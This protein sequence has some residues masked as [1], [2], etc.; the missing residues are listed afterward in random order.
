MN[1]TVSWVVPPPSLPT[2]GFYV[3]YKPWDGVGN[4]N[5]IQAAGPLP[6][7]TTSYTITGLNP[8]TVYR[9]LVSHE[10]LGSSGGFTDESTYLNITCPII[11]V[12]QGGTP[13]NRNLATLYY[14]L[15]Y[16]D[17]LHITS[18]KVGIT[19][20]SGFPNG[21]PTPSFAPIG[22]T[23]YVLSGDLCT[24]P[25]Q[26]DCNLQS[27]D[28]LY[29]SGL[30]SA[31]GYFGLDTLNFQ[32]TCNGTANDPILFNESASYKFYVETIIDSNIIGIDIDF[33]T[34]DQGCI[35]FSSA[36]QW[37]SVDPIP[38]YDQVS[39]SICYNNCQVNL[40]LL[41]AT[42]QNWPGAYQYA[43]FTEDAASNQIPL[44]DN[45]GNPITTSDVSYS[46]YCPIEMTPSLTAAQLG[47]GMNVT[48]E[49]FNPA[50]SMPYNGVNL[51]FTGFNWTQVV[52][53][54]VNNINTNTSLTATAV[55]IGGIDFIKLEPCD[56]LQARIR[57]Y[58]PGIFSGN[59]GDIPQVDPPAAAQHGI[60]D[61]FV[62]TVPGV[63]DFVYGSRGLDSNTTDGAIQVTD[64]TN[65]TPTV[66]VNHQIDIPINQM[67]LVEDAPPTTAY[68][69]NHLEPNT[70]TDPYHC[71]TT[72]IVDNSGASWN[73]GF[74]YT[75]DD[76][77]SQQ[78]SV[79][80]QSNV[81]VD[82]VDLNTFVGL[83]T[84]ARIKY[85][86]VCQPTGHL[87]VLVEDFVGKLNVYKVEHLPPLPV[88][89]AS[90]TWSVTPQPLISSATDFVL[91]T[92]TTNAVYNVQSVSVVNN[93][94][95]VA[96]NPWTNNQ[97]NFYR[98]YAPTVTSVSKQAILYN[99]T[100]PSQ[101][102]FANDSNTLY[103]DA[104]ADVT[105][106]VADLSPGDTIY[107]LGQSDLFFTIYDAAGT[108]VND[109]YN[110][111]GFI[112]EP[113]GISPQ[114]DGKRYYIDGTNSNS[115]P[116]GT[117]SLRI[118]ANVTVGG[119]Y[120]TS[121]TN[122]ATVSSLLPGVQYRLF[123]N[124][125]GAL[126][127]NQ[128]RNVFY[129]SK[130]DGEIIELDQD[131]NQ[132]NQFSLL[133][134]AGNP[135]TEG[136]FQFAENPATGLTYAIMRSVNLS[137]S[138][139][140]ASPYYSKDV[141]RINGAGN[142]IAA[143]NGAARWNEN[144]SGALS[145]IANKLYFTSNQTRRIIEYDT[146][147]TTWT[148]KTIPD[149]Y[150]KSQTVE[151]IESAI[152]IPGP[153]NR[154][155]IIN[156][157]PNAVTPTI[158][159]NYL[160]SN[161]FIYDYD[162]NTIET[163]LMG[164]DT[165]PWTAAEANWNAKNLGE[166]FGEFN[167]FKDYCYG[168]MSIKI[169]NDKIYFKQYAE[170]RYYVATPF[171]ETG[172]AQIW[173]I[174]ENPDGTTGTISTYRLIRIYNIQSDG[175]LVPS[176]RTIY[177]YKYSRGLK[178]GPRYIVY[179]ANNSAVLGVTNSTSELILI[180]VND[181]TGY[182]G[183]PPLGGSVLNIPLSSRMVLY[184]DD[185]SL[186]HK[187]EDPATFAYDDNS[188]RIYIF[189]KQAGGQIYNFQVWGIGAVL[190]QSV[191]PV[192][193]LQ[194]NTGTPNNA[195]LYN[196]GGGSNGHNYPTVFNYT[197]NTIWQMGNEF[198]NTTPG[199]AE[200]DR[201]IKIFNATT[202]TLVNTINL[203]Q[204]GAVTNGATVTNGA[205]DLYHNHFYDP[206]FNQMV[207]YGK[208]NDRLLFIN[209]VTQAITYNGSIVSM[210]NLNRSP[211]LGA[212]NIGW[213]VPYNNGYLVDRNNVSTTDEFWTYI[214]P[215]FAE[216]DGVIHDYITIKVNN[217]A[218]VIHDQV[219]NPIQLYGWSFGHYKVQNATPLPG[220]DV[221]YWNSMYGLLDITITFNDV[222]EIAQM[223]PNRQIIKVENLNQG[224]TYDITNPL[225]VNQP[226]LPTFNTLNSID[227]FAIRADNVNLFNGDF[228]QFTFANPTYPNC[229]YIQLMQIL[230]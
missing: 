62:Y 22:R 191:T 175:S 222:L 8:N 187:I 174:G 228:L 99:Y 122:D 211:Q 195:G 181:L 148:V 127:Y 75:C 156:R 45:A 146:I 188:G 177:T 49:I 110:D 107:M 221:A 163:V 226:Q 186:T 168:G 171:A 176:A 87:I 68:Q 73:D 11:S 158:H 185:V 15:Y 128:N 219:S 3:Y 210:I 112:F 132:T 113:S 133:D 215:S 97:W 166:T 48:L 34:N 135:I 47:P 218:I 165:Y 179:D 90:G 100:P 155:I 25:G 170:E 98:I 17:S 83:N 205:R 198:R 145:F 193:I 78:I 190:S 105:F 184:T 130:G 64:L 164:A 61:G 70:N 121:S 84:W 46:V 63:G 32:N 116:V 173:A 151:L 33:V 196:T 52:N 20:L 21:C 27:L 120:N 77:Y 167:G 109:Q 111:W 106:N 55:K 142:A 203:T 117:P 108:W 123:Y 79:Y 39:G 53:T 223:D 14:S 178:R 138:T 136:A 36:D 57:I 129:F 81:K 71:L 104:A 85:I 82:F 42:S 114:L 93:S 74:V 204:L 51:D 229:P 172:I 153:V 94:I 147:A 26:F 56:I 208:A 10:C 69:M 124:R 72:A 38:N 180:Y 220:F 7:G 31:V 169:Y 206:T 224:W 80:D 152:R 126:F 86:E 12:W 201:I 60:S 50:L 182:Y 4:N 197:T 230:F 125:C 43:Y 227:F 212:Q 202:M 139:G 16:P 216:Y 194:G 119:Y 183:G 140:P 29:P 217:A 95:T 44:V 35:T 18:A 115:L 30:T 154:F 54:I 92:I 37:N 159:T 23:T 225:H 149:V 160:C 141:Y 157:L 134:S 5:W 67:I 161:L 88:P 6:A 207:Y 19:T 102:N 28:F 65:L 24:N 96:G 1:I 131:G 41:D 40:S 118:T 101:P 2:A 76:L 89:P 189:G 9:V 66:N 150:K 162:A 103:I 214:Q 200:T 13:I 192:P 58:G 143:I 91:G 199:N 144:I 209:P 59:G 213:I 137:D